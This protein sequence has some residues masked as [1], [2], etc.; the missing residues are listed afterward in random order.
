MNKIEHFSNKYSK[1]GDPLV[2]ILAII[3]ILLAN[4]VGGEYR[5]LVVLC[6]VIIA[7]I[8]VLISQT[9]EKIKNTNRNQEEKI[10]NTDDEDREGFKTALN[11]FLIAI[12]ISL[13]GI[14]IF[15]NISSFFN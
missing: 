8:N 10:K 5:A 1:L 11:Y 7:A 14:T 3:L 13:I 2:F 6:G 15:I 9:I 12:G 4:L